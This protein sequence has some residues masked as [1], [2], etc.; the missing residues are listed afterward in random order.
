MRCSPRTKSQDYKKIDS[1]TRLYRGININDT[2]KELFYAGE[3]MHV[4]YAASVPSMVSTKIL[5]LYSK[6]QSFLG[7]CST[8]RESRVRMLHGNG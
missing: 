2:T 4:A 3:L 6:Y 7:D 1:K 8:P 5:E